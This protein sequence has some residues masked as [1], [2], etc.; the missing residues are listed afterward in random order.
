MTISGALQ[1]DKDATYTSKDGVIRV[2]FE[3]CLISLD[4]ASIVAQE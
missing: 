2:T 3:I 4:P 1:P